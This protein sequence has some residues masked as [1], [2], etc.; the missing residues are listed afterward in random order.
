MNEENR[1]TIEISEEKITNVN[2][3]TKGYYKKLRENIRKKLSKVEKYLGKNGVEI[4]LLAPDLFVLLTRLIKDA[5]VDTRKKVILGTVVAY[6]VLPTDILPE[7][8]TGAIGYLDDILITLYVI[9]SLFADTDLEVLL[10]NWP[11]NP[12]VIKNIHFY[13]QKAKELL[14]TFGGNLEQKATK[15]AQLMLQSGKKE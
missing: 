4:I 2:E 13:A 3:N 15:F 8:L 6:W 9:D 5:R 10:D 1:E 7:I 11:G 12:E 14:A